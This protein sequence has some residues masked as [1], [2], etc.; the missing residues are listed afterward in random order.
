MKQYW[1]RIGMKYRLGLI[2]NP[3]AGMGG[4]VGLKGTDGDLVEKARAMGASPLAETRA[5]TALDALAE[6]REKLLIL[7]CPGEMG[8][9]AAEQAGLRSTT[10][11][12]IKREETTAEDT[13]AAASK[14]LEYDPE[15]VLFVGGDG[16]ARDMLATVDRKVPV[17]GVPSG[18]KMHS[19]VFAATARA[20]GEVVARYLRS[21]DRESLLRE[22]EI[23]D[24]EKTS[25]GTNGLSPRLFGMMLAPCMNV[26]VPGAK[27]SSSISEHAALEL[28]VLRSSEMIGDTRVS[29]IGPGSTMLMLKR[30]LGFEGTP[31]GIDVVQHG[32]C[33]AKDVNEQ[34]ILDLIADRPARIIVSIV[35]GQGFLF[36]RGNQQLSARVIREVGQE[37]IVIASSL[38]KLAALSSGCLLVDTG[39]EELDERLAGHMP[40]IVSNLKTV[41]MPVKNAS[42]EVL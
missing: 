21:D 9:T 18:V 38:D 37:N 1:H 10:I 2:I 32:R 36:G 4:S 24:R 7:T 27:A 41:I 14:M 28:A 5:I 26:L 13:R 25:R 6:F 17:L 33:L 42:T 23:L 16:T 35:G 19:A 29:L 40:V 30:Q 39:D 3:I 15:M 22:A 12:S 20:A 34:N 31:L 8:A 11:S